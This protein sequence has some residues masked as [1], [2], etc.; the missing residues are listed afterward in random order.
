MIQ[1]T[2]IIQGYDEVE[3]EIMDIKIH[4]KTFTIFEVSSTSPVSL[5]VI[6]SGGIDS[7]G[8]LRSTPTPELLNDTFNSCRASLSTVNPCF[9]AYNFGYYNEKNNYREMIVLISFIPE[10]ADFRNK[11]AMAS[12]TAALRSSLQISTLFQI[13]DLAEF[14][15]KG[16]MNECSSIQRK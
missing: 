9:I 8:D 7:S 2:D 4:K 15:F 13:D 10:N 12:N 5:V 3:K 6:V 14:T 11:I 16:L 1:S